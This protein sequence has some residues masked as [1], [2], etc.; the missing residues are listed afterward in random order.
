MN[1]PC[2]PTPAQFELLPFAHSW[3]ALH[4]APKG[5]IQFVGSRLL[6]AF[7]TLA[8]RHFLKSLFEAGYTIVAFPFRFARNHWS[9]ALNL[10]DE[11]YAVRAALM[12]AAV[13][14]GYSTA[15]YLEAKNYTWVGHGL[16]CKYVL[17]LE[18]LSLPMDE[19]S[20][21][22]QTLGQEISLA[23][24]RQLR[25]GLACIQT[26]LGYL[27][28]RIWQL[29]GQA[30]SYGKPS[31]KDEASLLLAPV[32]ADNGARLE[33]VCGSLLTMRPSVN[34]THALI[35]QSQLFHLTG[36]LQFARDRTA[37]DT[38]HQLMQEQTHLRR[39]LLKGNHLEPVGIQIGPLVVDFNP[40]DKFIQPLENR[41]LE[42]KALA[43]LERLR[44]VPPAF[45]RQSRRA[46]VHK[47][48]PSIA[49]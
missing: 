20:A 10:L 3:V 4:P 48:H 40:L 44:H 15:V 24:E 17:L 19:L 21:Q 2:L 32:V 47:K 49:A 43:F 45:S 11:H 8:Y 29:T 31:I 13:A 23:A 33:R 41:D 37:A 9:V 5:V 14:K 12:E 26:S 35:E 6:G 39:R 1:C 16:G 30:I 27:E 25:Q 46:A 22:L 18:I 36:L 7:P 34:H 42:L 38:C 28:R